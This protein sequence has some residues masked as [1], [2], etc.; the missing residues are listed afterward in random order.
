MLVNAGQTWLTTPITTLGYSLD[1]ASV[2]EELVYQSLRE[3][4]SISIISGT[5][6]AVTR[7]QRKTVLSEQNAEYGITS[8]ILQIDSLIFVH[9]EKWDISGNSLYARQFEVRNGDN[10]SVVIDYITSCLIEEKDVNVKKIPSKDGV[11]KKLHIAV[12]DLESSVISKSDA[13]LITDQVMDAIV[14]SKQFRVLERSNMNRILKEQEFQ[15]SGIVKQSSMIEIGELLGVQAVLSTQ[16]H[17]VGEYYTLSVQL[18]S[19]KTGEIEKHY[20]LQEDSLTL[21]ALIG[22]KVHEAVAK[23]ISDTISAS[24]QKKVRSSEKA[25]DPV[26]NEGA[27]PLSCRDSYI[28][29][30]Y[31]LRDEISRVDSTSED[32][33]IRLL[34]SERLIQYAQELYCSGIYDQAVEVI[35]R[36]LKDSIR[37]EGTPYAKSLIECKANCGFHL[38]NQEIVDDAVYESEKRYGRNSM[39]TAKTVLFQGHMMLNQNVDSAADFYRNWKKEYEPLR[40]KAAKEFSG[41]GNNPYRSPYHFIEYEFS[42]AIILKSDIYALYGLIGYPSNWKN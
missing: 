17:K 29:A 1:R 6:S 33:S 12:I 28:P 40:K 5:S 34:R 19:V 20:L 31:D 37:Y 39:Q 42:R 23:M 14:R 27:D 2:L 32:L 10:I 9:L 41:T 25:Q 3:K 7:E 38:Q 18:T 4:G 30:K 13:S 35:N 16:L 11:G 21:K 36:A 22:G 24:P 8:K 15:M 26:I